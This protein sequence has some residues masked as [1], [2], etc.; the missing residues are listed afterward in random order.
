M[1]LSAEYFKDIVRALRHLML[2][3]M[4]CLGQKV[5]FLNEFEKALIIA[6]HPDDEIFGCGGLLTLCAKSGKHA[7]ILFI[8]NGE[9]SHK[10]CCQMPPSKIGA[11]RQ[12]SAFEANKVFGFNSS[13]LQFLEW[14]DGKI[15]TAGH[16]DFIKLTEKIVEAMIQLKP[17]VVFCPHPFE[18]WPD[19]IAS[20][21]L[22]RAALKM[23]VTDARPKLY[24][25]CVWLWFSMPLKKAWLINWRNARL[26][27]ITTVSHNKRQAIKIYLNALAPC[28]TPWIGKLPPQ[29]LNAFKW[30]KELYFEVSND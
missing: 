14:E 1:N 28:G 24:H 17:D 21:A 11:Q 6:P 12:K 30:H 13:N 26:L 16:V 29:F 3:Q 25:Y 18:G 22:T 5:N 15:P 27:D 9:A 2:K 4:A 19:H 23:L 8:T 20:E 7:N 10:G